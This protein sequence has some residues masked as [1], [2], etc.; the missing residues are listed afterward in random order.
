MERTS[1]EPQALMD[2]RYIALLSR[3]AEAGVCFKQHLHSGCM[4]RIN[5]MLRLYH[6]DRPSHSNSSQSFTQLLEVINQL[7]AAFLDPKKLN[8]CC[9]Q[10]ADFGAS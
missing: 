6:H 4:E 2:D 5:I 1:R 3:R 9:N 7:L 10:G 8:T